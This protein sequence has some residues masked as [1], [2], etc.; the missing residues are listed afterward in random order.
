MRNHN[1]NYFKYLNLRIIKLN[2]IIEFYNI[3]SIYIY[4]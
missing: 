3:Y 4:I 2:Q 1:P